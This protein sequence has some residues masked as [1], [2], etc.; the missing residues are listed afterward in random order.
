MQ[1]NKKESLTILVGLAVI[2]CAVD[3]LAFSE[4]NEENGFIIAAFI[5]IGLVAGLFAW[6]YYRFKNKKNCRFSI[7]LLIVRLLNLVN[8]ISLKKI[9]SRIWQHLVKKSELAAS[10]E[11]HLTHQ[12]LADEMRS[13]REVFSR[14]LTQM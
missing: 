8:S 13:T 9:D 11:L 5:H 7:L 1:N 4:V 12:Q 6:S 10:R 2:I 3:F 14:L